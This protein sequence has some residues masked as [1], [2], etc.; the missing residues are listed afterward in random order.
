MRDTF[1]S[2]NIRDFEQRYV[3]TYGWLY[4]ED[5]QRNFVYVK[6][7]DDDAV[8]F[9]AGRGPQFSVLIDSGL[10]FEFIPVDRGWYA[11]NDGHLY[12]LTR[13]PARQWRR[14]ISH[15]NTEAYRGGEP[16]EISY[17]L[18]NGIFNHNQIPFR[19]GVNALISPHF[20]VISGAVKF[21]SETVG[22]Q[23]GD[24]LRLLTPLVYHE[25]LSAIK[26]SPVP[27]DFKV[28]V[29]E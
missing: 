8:Y 5:G 26:R 18:L 13:K 20:C 19:N 4:R 16:A 22:Y 9:S 17:A 24:T 29:D 10:E 6:S 14:G 3:D 25:L 1:N 2:D 23:D 7:H 15:T 28:T 12:Y 11:S 27:L 21:Y